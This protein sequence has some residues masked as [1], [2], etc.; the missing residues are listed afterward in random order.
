MMF[1]GGSSTVEKQ[2]LG[3]MVPYSLNH[4][5]SFY[6]FIFS[7]CILQHPSQLSTIN[8]ADT[9]FDSVAAM[10]EKYKDK[11]YKL[12]PRDPDVST[13][14]QPMSHLYLGKLKSCHACL[15]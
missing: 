2:S 7:T 9:R 10:L 11:L 12:D 3:L 15:A 8:M 4:H 14:F 1:R 13:T 5:S 6:S